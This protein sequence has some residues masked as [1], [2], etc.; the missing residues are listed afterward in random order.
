M[1]HP[2]IQRE[3]TAE[4]ERRTKLPRQKSS[5]LD[6][7]QANASND[8]NSNRKVP[9]KADFFFK[10]RLFRSLKI[11]PNQ[12]QD[13]FTVNTTLCGGTESDHGVCGVCSKKSS[14]GETCVDV[15]VI[16]SND[17]MENIC[18]ICH[19]SPSSEKL[20]KPCLCKG[21]IL[22]ILIK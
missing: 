10:G 16:R 8:S 13:V 14:K 9:S 22:E 4:N 20:I 3:R 7:I 15:N 2:N 18:R 6:A 17:S 11:S 19:D 5:S 21:I 12:A 1:L